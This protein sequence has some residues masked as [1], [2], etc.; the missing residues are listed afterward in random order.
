M[1]LWTHCGNMKTR[2]YCLFTFYLQGIMQVA[3]RFASFHHYSYK[4]RRYLQ[5]RFQM[6]KQIQNVRKSVSARVWIQI[7]ILLTKESLWLL[8][9]N[10]YI[11]CSRSLVLVSLLYSNFGGVIELS[12]YIQCILSAGHLLSALADM[13][14]V[15]DSRDLLLKSFQNQLQK[16]ACKKTNS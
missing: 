5:N 1:R 12:F 7:L 11:S 16:T 15:E 3:H 13:I 6:S 9:L 10:K 8:H 14:L 2:I 4:W